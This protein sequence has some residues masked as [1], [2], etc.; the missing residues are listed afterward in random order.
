MQIACLFFLFALSFAG[1]EGIV[2]YS[3][4]AKPVKFN[5]YLARETNES[6]LIAVKPPGTGQEVYREAAPFLRDADVASASVA[7]DQFG[8]PAVRIYLADSAVTRKFTED[9]TG[10]IARGIME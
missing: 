1:C 3:P 9:Q 5:L 2:S 6:E 8:Q 10:E 7:Q 4:P